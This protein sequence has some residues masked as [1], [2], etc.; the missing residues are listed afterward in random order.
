[1]RRRRRCRAPCALSVAVASGSNPPSWWPHAARSRAIDAGGLQ[2]HV[3][4]WQ[5]KPSAPVALLLHGT[6]AATHTW[7]H[8]APLLAPHFQVIAPD[9]PGH[10]FTS[11]PAQQALTLPAVAQ[12][13]GELLG[14]MQLRPAL[15]VG[16]SAGAA[17]A[18]SMVT[19]GGTAPDLTVSIG[20]AILPLQGPVGRMFLPLA[21]LLTVN[22]FVPPTFAAVAR[23]PSVARRLIDST[24][25]RIDAE[26]QRCY[27]HLMANATH[28]AGALRL[29]ASW[30]LQPLADALP[31]WR[32]P[33]LLIAGADDRTLPASHSQRV[34]ALAGDGLWPC[35]VLPRLGHLAH[36]E[37]A[38]AVFAPLWA[39]WRQRASGRARPD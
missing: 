22:P 17:V 15:V 25:S 35:V 13:V 29:M 26:G 8:L 28:A 14:A 37:D 16:H 21:R 24:G 38:A 5:H 36:E 7:R 30:D 34:Q 4:Q 32:A 9:L 33:L 23:L 31:Q 19:A 27:A 3:Q 18:M 20:G 10:G 1:M 2:W 6:G 39:A 12:A 11:T